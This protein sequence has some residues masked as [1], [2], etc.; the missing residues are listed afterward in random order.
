VNDFAEELIKQYGE[1]RFYHCSNRTTP[2]AKT[3]LVYIVL[4]EN[5]TQ[6][7]CNSFFRSIGLEQ[8]VWRYHP[9]RKDFMSKRLLD[10]PNFALDLHEEMCRIA[11]GFC[12]WWKEFG[13]RTHKLP[14]HLHA[15]MVLDKKNEWV[16]QY[17]KL[18]ETF[19]DWQLK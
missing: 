1:D 15:R 3:T 8:C 13:L 4:N 11:F 16:D 19:P 9:D 17:V 14:F 5:C 6:E 10:D 18:I 7:S 12:R 2:P